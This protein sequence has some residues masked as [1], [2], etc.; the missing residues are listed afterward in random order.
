MDLVRG[1]ELF[2]EIEQHGELGTKTARKYFQELVDGIDY[3]HQR[4]VFHRDLKPENLLVDENG[5]LKI[6]DFGVSSMKGDTTENDLLYTACG[7]PYYCAPEIINGAEGGYSGVK[8]DVWSCG[9]ILYLLLTGNLP[10][11]STDMRLLYEE[12]NDCKVFYPHWMDADAKDLISHILKKDPAARFSLQDVINHPWFLVDYEHHRPESSS[13]SGNIGRNRSSNRRNSASSS[14][15]GRRSSSRRNSKGKRSSQKGRQS[16]ES[17]QTGSTVDDNKGSALSAVPERPCLLPVESENDLLNKDNNSP[18]ESPPILREDSVEAANP[19]TT[20]D[21]QIES[22]SRVDLPGAHVSSPVEVPKA[23][24]SAAKQRNLGDQ[25]YDNKRSQTQKDMS[26]YEDKEVRV[27]IRAALPGKAENKIERVT[28]ELEELDIECAED[29]S[30]L[31]STLKTRA[32]VTRWLEENSK[33][34]SITCM[35]IAEFLF[36]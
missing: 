18:S 20:E 23:E 8:I 28:K 31:S 9:I 16:S 5:T 14:K 30:F 25:T 36:L 15:D 27:L 32:A 22:H 12:I 1:G 4:G 6:T 26:E 2:E 13:L 35:R 24:N 10:F 29:L 11:Q 21:E 3:C 33:L 34:Q 17:L 7:T 19:P